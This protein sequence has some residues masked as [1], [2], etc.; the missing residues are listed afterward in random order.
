MGGMLLH[1]DTLFWF[2][3]AKKQQV[4]ILEYLG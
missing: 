1:L 4:R 3:V 2:Q